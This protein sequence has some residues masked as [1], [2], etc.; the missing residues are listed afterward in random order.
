MQIFRIV[1]CFS[2]FILRKISLKII[3]VIL[4]NVKTELCIW[5]TNY[6]TLILN[7]KNKFQIPIFATFITSILGQT[8]LK[9]YY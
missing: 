6:Y 9:K 8:M 1:F 5:K 7:F 2:K 3:K 4:K